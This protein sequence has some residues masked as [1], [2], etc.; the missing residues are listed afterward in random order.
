MPHP[1]LLVIFGLILNA[2]GSFIMLRW[3]VLPN[4]VIRHPESGIWY[5]VGSWTN[6]TAPKWKVRVARLGPALL[7]LGFLAQL[8]GALLSGLSLD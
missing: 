6:K 7:F 1:L 4:A 2:A 5:E 3:Q 8:A